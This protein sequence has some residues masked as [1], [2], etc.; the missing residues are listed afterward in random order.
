M[1]NVGTLTCCRPASLGS[2]TGATEAAGTG[3]EPQTG[4]VPE[5]PVPRR[6]LFRDGQDQNRMTAGRLGPLC[7]APAGPPA[8]H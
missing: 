5:S 4:R 1:S 6:A 2:A 7:A 3:T 8:R